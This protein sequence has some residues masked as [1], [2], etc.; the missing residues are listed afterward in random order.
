MP[1]SY[2]ADIENDISFEDYAL[3]CARR[4]GACMHQRDN[5]IEEKPKLRTESV[6]H[7]DALSKAKKIIVELEAMPGV[8]ARTKY[9]EKIIKEEEAFNQK[10]FNKKIILKNKYIDMLS[11]A[12]KWDPPTPDHEQLKKFMIDQINESINFDCDTNYEMENLTALS[13]VNPLDKYKEVLRRAY[14]DIEY[15]ETELFKERE[16]GADAN[17]WIIALYDSLGIKYDSE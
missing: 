10:S 7:T 1:S 3:M 8:N 14:N 11:K 15:H 6:Y 16:R 2:T 13:K 17:K 5:P 4:F 9:G 12:C